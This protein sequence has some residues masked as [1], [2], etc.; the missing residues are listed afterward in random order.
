M[1]LIFFLI[2]RN[3]IVRI[4]LLVRVFKFISKQ[5]AGYSFWKKCTELGF[6]AR[7]GCYIIKSGADTRKNKNV[8]AK[9]EEEN[10]SWT[11]RCLTKTNIV[12]WK[13]EETAVAR[14]W[15]RR[16]SDAS[17]QGAVPTHC[18]VNSYYI[19]MRSVQFKVQSDPRLVKVS[20]A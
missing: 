16:N 5:V 17:K 4:C 11:P 20:K 14:K 9:S 2:K 7:R 12:K 3:D 1:T 18:P 6:G 19:S 13:T 8:I 10:P 15:R